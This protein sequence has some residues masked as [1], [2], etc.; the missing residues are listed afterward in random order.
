VMATATHSLPADGPR[1]TAAFL[2]ADLAILAARPAVYD[3][4]TENV[5]R[6]YAHVADDD[7]CTGRKATLESFLERDRLFFT[8]AGQARFEATARA[9]LRREIKSLTR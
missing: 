1:E 6:E 4:Y 7:F 8:T 5:R 9:N 2:D 3:S